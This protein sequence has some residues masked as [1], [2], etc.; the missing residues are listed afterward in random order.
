MI[1][2]YVDAS[3]II[4]SARRAEIDIDFLRLKI[5]LEDKYDVEKVY[6]FTPNLK[7]T[8]DENNALINAGFEVVFK[9]I[10]HENDKT[11]ANCDVEISHYITKHIE[12]KMVSGMVLLSGDGDFF[13]LLEYAK[14]NNVS[15]DIVSTDPQSTSKLLKR[16]FYNKIT[17]LI[18]IKDR[19]EKEKPPTNT[20]DRKGN[21][22]VI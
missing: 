10:Y 20:E 1:I 8:K 18:D 14:I 11:K 7:S 19:L 5:Y 4:L 2:A 17:F 9:E 3:N 6:Y 16:R 12:N 21:F 22:S 13:I 15:L